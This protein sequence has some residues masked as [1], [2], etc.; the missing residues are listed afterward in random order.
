ME[1]NLSSVNLQVG[2]VESDVFRYSE[3]YI[4]DNLELANY[5]KLFLALEIDEGVFEAEQL[6]EI[7]LGT[8]HQ[9]LYRNL[10]EDPYNSF[11]NALQDINEKLG[12]FAKHKGDLWV[13]HINAVIG[14]L[15]T[16]MLHL[17]QVG[18]SQ[19]F[20]LRNNK[21]NN[22]SEGLAPE[23][24]ELSAENNFLNISSGPLAEGDILIFSSG[25]LLSA[26]SEEALINGLVTADLSNEESVARNIQTLDSLQLLIAEVKEL[27]TAELA[28]EIEADAS[29]EQDEL[30]EEEIKEL[31]EVTSFEDLS[32]PNFWQKILLGFETIVLSPLKNRKLSDEARLKDKL[33][34]LADRH[35]TTGKKSKATNTYEIF[36]ENTSKSL[37][38]L[39]SGRRQFM[40]ARPRT[41]SRL[42]LA[43]SAFIILAVL[44]M[45]YW[46]FSA[47][48]AE[49]AQFDQLLQE[50]SEE[51]SMAETR[52]IYD[53]E[54]A[55][56]LLIQVQNKIIQL[57]ESEM[58]EYK[59][60][61]EAEQ[62]KLQSLLDRVDNVYREA[63][64]E[65]AFDLAT[66]RADV[67]AR[68]FVS[69]GSSLY[70]FDKNAIYRLILDEVNMRTVTVSGA[71]NFDIKD[72]AFLT[73]EGGIV[74]Y[75]SDNQLIKYK[76]DN[77]T[78][79]ELPQGGFKNAIAID[80]YDRRKML[81]FLDPSENEIWRYSP[82]NDQYGEP[83]KKNIGLDLSQAV[84]FG[85]DGAI[86]I[87][88]A[89]GKVSKIYGDEQTPFE[90]TGL[91]QA[92]DS[93]RK[94]FVDQDEASGLVY[95][96]D[97]NNQRVVVTGKGGVYKAQYVFEKIDNLIDL[98][99]NYDENILYVLSSDGKVYKTELRP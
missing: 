73:Q 3:L 6:A 75:T 19:A 49:R 85:I 4:P 21:L 95:I 83:S 79:T 80:D 53:I 41:N 99:A 36:K 35:R 39:F 55:K 50:I 62:L 5:G 96:L 93:P 61:G 23:Q 43:V 44:I 94:I 70:A 38:K 22:I 69:S 34:K 54:G 42:V 63:V 33:D 30:L 56:R 11:E 82:E 8:L 10:E 27:K 7:I 48:R 37:Q 31:E 26:I 87:L 2:E 89:D 47:G 59:A 71:E 13:G 78:L 45:W 25:D 92:L 68:G 77:F 72:S 74:M 51:R 28:P 84:D 98:Y 81:Y 66:K 67:E 24:D 76:D 86:Y 65:I 32:E 52:A 46:N 88:N 17:T 14:F 12:E 15:A 57:K 64:P 16:N 9:N 58:A 97:Q 18:E 20:L 1:L 91:I 90:I 29:V 40:T 60:I